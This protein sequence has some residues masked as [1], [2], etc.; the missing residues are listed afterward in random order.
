VACGAAKIYDESGETSAIEL[1]SG[2]MRGS[3][4]EKAWQS[5]LSIKALRIIE[6][7]R[8]K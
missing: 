6:Q 1:N 4:G 5:S 7:H 2:G 8:K 3:K